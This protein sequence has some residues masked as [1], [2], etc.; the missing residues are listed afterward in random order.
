MRLKKRISMLLASLMLISVLQVSA[1]ATGVQLRIQAPETL[2]SEGETFN[3]AVSIAGNPGVSAVQF[4]LDF[5]RRVVS[6][7]TASV[8]GV[9]AGSL[10]ATN[11]KAKDG[12]IVAAATVNP[13]KADGTLAE[14]TFRVLKS[15]DAAFSLKDAVFTDA[16]GNTIETNVPSLFVG[17]GTASG[18]KTDS[19]Y[20]DGKSEKTQTFS[21]VPES[22]WGYE[23]IET[24]AANGIVGGMG[25]GTF[26]P[27]R[28]MTRAEFVSMLWRMADKANAVKEAD[29]TD[30][31]QNA[32]YAAAVNWAYEKG[33]VKGTSATTFNPNGKITR[34]ETVTILFNYNGGVSGTELLLSAAYDSQYQD[35]GKIAVWAKSAMYWAIYN[36]VIVGTSDTTVSPLETTT[37]AE[38]TTML[39]QYNK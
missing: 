16:N 22:F 4:T 7:E 10:A 3:V 26:E 30:V 6:C 13:T 35:S 34:Q 21:D 15:G 14:F 20:T 25:N 19:Q 2:P 8:G 31:P 23:F 24:A 5:D 27:N 12:A 36:G 38:A 28:E 33:V 29:F 17:T 39:V 32:W 1:L 9:L 11:P 37:R 18:D